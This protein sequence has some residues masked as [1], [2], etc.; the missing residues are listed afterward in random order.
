[1]TS[2]WQLALVAGAITALG[3]CNP[4]QD[5][6]SA[7]AGQLK[8][9]ETRLKSRLAKATAANTVKTPLALWIMPAVLREI[10]GLALTPDG[11]LLT[12]GDEIARIYEIDPRRGSVVKSFNVGKSVHGDFE[13]LTVAGSDLYLMMSKGVLLQF[14]EGADGQRVPFTTHDLKLGKECEFEGVAFEKDSAWLVLPCKEVHVKDL[15]DDIVLYRWR[16]GTRAKDGITT[17]AVPLSEVIGSN[18]WK[19]FRPSDI[20]IDPV[21]GNYVLIS[22]LEKGMAVITPAGDV[23]WSGPLPGKHH[24]AE[25]VA[26]GKDGLLIISDEGS[27]KPATIAVYRWVPPEPGQAPQ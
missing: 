15:K 11:R 22:S 13:G 2:G 27:S 6:S 26:I 5:A 18:K 9:R 10:S 8:A 23:V 24:Q 19:K 1:M 20:S 25:G 12:H 4:K 7:H 14:K 3:G 17:L 16:L 21:T